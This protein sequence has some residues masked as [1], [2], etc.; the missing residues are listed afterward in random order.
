MLEAC[1]MTILDLTDAKIQSLLIKEKVVVNPRARQKHEAKHT[2]QDFEVKS[3]DGAD[4]FRLFIRQSLVIQAGFSVG[5]VWISPSKEEAILMRCNGSDYL[6][7]NRIEGS[8]FDE[9]FHI[10]IAT[11]RYV[12]AGL[13]AESYAEISKDYQNV[14]DAK[15]HLCRACN[16]SG[17]E[18]DSDEKT[19]SLFDRE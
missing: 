16:I 11:E 18:K 15:H 12:S 3:K 2:R 19:M 10:H 1:I 4:D 9:E 17:F 13:R 8:N 14:N 5:L 6:H 7:R